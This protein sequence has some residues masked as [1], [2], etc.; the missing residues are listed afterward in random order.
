M[1]SAE[2]L[3]NSPVTSNQAVP[4][5]YG[6][7]KPIS[8]AGPCDADVQRSKELEKVLIDRLAILCT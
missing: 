7:T 4:K 8:L 2:G 6:V 1:G 3:S 5:C